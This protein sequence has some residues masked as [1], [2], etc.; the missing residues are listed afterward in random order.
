PASSSFRLRLAT[1][2]AMVVLALAPGARAVHAQA[3]VASHPHPEFGIGPLLL[4]VTVGKDDLRP[5]HR[6]ITVTVSWSIVAP[7]DRAADLAQDL[8]LLWPGEVAGASGADG[9]DP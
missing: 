6:P 4:S 3:F 8:Y 1:V 5:A 9:A 2:V 7:S